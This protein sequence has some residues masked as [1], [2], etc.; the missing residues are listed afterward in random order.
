MQPFH[1]FMFGV[2]VIPH[3]NAMSHFLIGIDPYGMK[4]YGEE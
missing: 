1:A 4:S 2:A 3:I